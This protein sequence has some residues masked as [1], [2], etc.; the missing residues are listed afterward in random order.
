[1]LDKL[2]GLLKVAETAI[3]NLD[4]NSVLILVL[5]GIT[6]KRL[7]K[8]CLKM[9]IKSFNMLNH[10]MKSF[11]TVLLVVLLVLATSARAI[12]I[13]RDDK[14]KATIAV[15]DDFIKDAKSIA[16]KVS[17]TV[18]LTAITVPPVTLVENSRAQA[19]IVIPAGS[20]SLEAINLQSYIE[21]V[22]GARLAIVAEDKLLE[23]KNGASRVFVG[24]CIAANRVLDIK[25]L[26]PEGFVIKTDG[27]DL[28]I[29]GRDTTNTGMQVKGTF[30]GVC[31]FLERYLGVRW[32]MP[33]PVGEV[34]P[35]QAT[36]QIASADI[37]QE[38]ML[39]QRRIR[40]WEDQRARVPPKIL[41]EWGVSIAE[42]EIT[43][44]STAE[45]WIEYQR[46]G[47]RVWVE[48]GHSF[49][50]WWDKYRDKYP[51]IFAMQPNGTRI[52]SNRREQ[53]CVSNP[54]LWDLVAQEKIKELL[55]NPNLIAASIS[56]NDNGGNNFC[57]CERCRS[58]DSP[59]ARELYKKDPKMFQRLGPLTDRY[60]RFYNEVAKRVKKEM[61]DRYL[62]CYAYYVYSRAPVVL[63]H[64]E[65]NLI[66]GY[67]GFDSEEYLNDA[68]RKTAREEW[69]KWSKLAKQLFLRPNLLLQPIGLPINYTHKIAEDLRFM[70][71]HGMRMTE[72]DAWFGNWGTQGLDYYVLAKLLWD[73]YREVDPIIDDYC[74]AAYGPGAN[75]MKEYYRREEDL[76]NRIAAAGTPKQD[77]D[78]RLT[79][80]NKLTDCWTDSI[81]T[82]LQACVEKA[83]EAIG[84]SDTA[85]LDRVH[86]VSMGLEY[87]K[88]TRDLLAAAADVRTGKSTLEEFKKIKTETD[89][90]YKSLALS[91]AVAVECNYSDI[92]SG[93]SL[94]PILK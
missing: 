62:G 30:Y 53:M 93:L 86:M 61:P 64:L 4:S 14:T 21:K 58:W 90:Y 60:F 35:K 9:K 77:L 92:Q 5:V 3:K 85:A 75:A 37:R 12:T 88:K 39:L 47:N 10:Q 76:T 82:E 89:K 74:R 48:Y 50:G 46:L 94:K 7:N 20:K 73:P 13:M 87:T 79:N 27:N 16:S 81:L 83:A 91:W 26:Q 31:E 38:P 6:N 49:E 68:A 11:I 15:H 44:A 45:P 80:L 18:S 54:T 57:C 36:I 23:T 84:S 34:T 17:D 24:P 25:R 52:N 28:F 2:R 59:E 32:L 71:D 40:E 66:I 55:A 56:P 43:F 63:E 22:S 8:N 78:W 65:D 51:D 19:V 33:G 67:V 41:T 69:F 1:M 42:W 72:F 29:V 70:V